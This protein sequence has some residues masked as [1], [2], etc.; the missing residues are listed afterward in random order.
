MSRLGLCL[1]LSVGLAIGVLF[2][3]DPKLDLEVARSVHALRYSGVLNWAEPAISALRDFNLYLIIG[4]I[5]LSATC[6]AFQLRRHSGTLPPLRACVLVLLAIAIG[7]GVIVNAVLKENWSRPRPGVVLASGDE[8]AF[9]AWWDPDRE[10]PAELFVRVRGGICSVCDVGGR[11]CFATGHPLHRH[12]PGTPLRRADQRHTRGCRRTFRQRRDLCRRHPG[13]GRVDA[14][15]AHLPVARDVRQ[16]SAH[17]ICSSLCGEPIVQ[18]GCRCS[19]RSPPPCFKGD[20]WHD[21]CTLSLD[22]GAHRFGSGSSG[23]RRFVK[24]RETALEIGDQVAGIFKPDVEAKTRAARVPGRGSAVVLA[25]VD[26]DKAL[27]ASP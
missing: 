7:P 19:S 13:F 26:D 11:G 4:L 22:S 20:G 18:R 24:R 21:I 17:A 14:S 12:Y 9:R 5:A 3:I 27:V 15:R 8:S 1:T 25:I 23:A 10:L 2:A 16:R 6:I